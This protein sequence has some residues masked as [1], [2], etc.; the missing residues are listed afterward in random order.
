MGE[1][2]K[3][4][5]VKLRDELTKRG[6]PKTGLKAVLVARLTEADAQ[7]ES[8]TQASNVQVPVLKTAEDSQTVKEGAPTRAQDQS[9][10]GEG[11]PTINDTESLVES[12][13]NENENGKNIIETLE[14]ATENA[15]A[16]EHQHSALEH[17]RLGQTP[18][19][20]TTKEDRTISPVEKVPPDT[21]A[22]MATVEKDLK[23]AKLHKSQGATSDL[24]HVPVET[25]TTLNEE[26][27]APINASAESTQLS[28]NAED[29]LDSKKRKRRSQ[30]PPPSAVEA[31]QKRAKAEDGSPRVR[32]PE[33]QVTC[34]VADGHH[35]DA[36]DTAMAD[37]RPD[38]VPDD[39]PVSRKVDSAIDNDV[40]MQEDTSILREEANAKTSFSPNQDSAE[41][42]HSESRPAK[43][44]TTPPST[45]IDSS[46]K[47]SPSDTRF[48]N[49]FTA[50]SKR[51][52][53]PI[54][55][56]LYP[57][58]EDRVVRPALHPATSALYVR[59]FMRPLHSGNLKDHLINLATPPDSASDTEI[60]TEFF[61]DPIRTHCLVQ[62]SST[63]AASRV[64]SGLHDRVWPDERTR[65]PL[66]VDFVPE[67]K[68]RKWIEVETEASGGRGQSAKRWEVV[69]EDEADGMKAYLQEAG[70]NQGPRPGVSTTIRPE[71]GQGVQGAPS[72]PRA[73]EPETRTAQPNTSS[74]TDSGKGF[75]ALDDLFK[76]TSAKPKLYYLPVGPKIVDKRL[77]KLAAGRGGG[78]G[79][80]M[81]RFTFEE[82][83][84]VDRGPEFGSRGRGGFGGRGAGY[85]GRGGTWR[86][87]NRREKR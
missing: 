52:G 51:D 2:D 53:S 67:E 87:D 27:A 50:P 72:G 17:T 37:L 25:Q 58:A 49:L 7:I 12:R 64:R 15:P 59:D 1:Y 42:D 48:K 84:L 38:E 55:Q 62:F 69:Y 80:E 78:R 23:D 19:H 14:P 86:G 46:F 41:H 32:L 34:I 45:N 56:T 16:I 74:K 70:S 43:M 18:E 66:W 76:S 39:F 85:M 71:G 20:D 6:L 65:K 44:E 63:S 30:S 61:L 13:K 68:L 3:F 22:D 60:V 9:E 47:P 26:I 73:K 5:V 24:D 77:D 54:R 33:D 75:K 10:E 31:A 57:D 4:T 82:D 8:E 29:L 21:E 79:E 11:A 35:E 40:S 81:R 28:S 36:K 83:V